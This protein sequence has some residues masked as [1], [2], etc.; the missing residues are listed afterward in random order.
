MSEIKK[1]LETIARLRDPES[2]C[3]WDL[4]QTHKSLVPYLLEESYEAAAAIEAGDSSEIKNELG[5]VLLQVVLHAQIAS[6]KGVFDFADVAASI[7]A[8]MVRRHPH[9]F[10]D[11]SFANEVEQKEFWE[12]EKLREKN[13]AQTPTGILS[14]LPKNTSA[15]MQAL[16]LQKRVAR[17]GFDWPEVAGVIEKV[18]E[19][20]VEIEQALH[21]KNVDH[22][23]EEFGDL[24]FAVVNL[25]RFLK[26]DAE[27]TL[28]SANQK[29]TLRFERMAEHLLTNTNKSLSECS[30]AEMEAAWQTVKDQ[31]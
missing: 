27:A 3:P 23:R 9:V 21:E 16:E 2:G 10:A 18:R 29:F 11:M 8:K 20:V 22:A 6:E 14:D 31:E 7:D 25:G 19:E 5:D 15:L 13:A 1:L 4:K 17:K 12:A 30:L 24:L 28:L 26:F